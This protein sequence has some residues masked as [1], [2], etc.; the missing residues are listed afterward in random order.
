MSRRP[1][2]VPSQLLNLSIPLDVHSKMTIHLYSDLE[3]RVPYGAYAAFLSERVR[4]FFSSARLD[5]APFINGDPGAFIVTG[6]PEAIAVLEK[7][8]K[9]ELP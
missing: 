1:N 7:A 9:G 4:E 3:Q 2:V 6:P 8:L 5:L